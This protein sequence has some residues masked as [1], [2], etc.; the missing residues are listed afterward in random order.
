MNRSETVG[1]G[2][3][4]DSEFVLT[5]SHLNKF[6][7]LQGNITEMVHAKATKKDRGR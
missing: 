4:E 5:D 7:N 1:K 6:K 3:D 2:K